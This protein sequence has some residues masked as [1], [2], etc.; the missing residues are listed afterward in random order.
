[1][2]ARCGRW[3]PPSWRWSARPSRATS[4]ACRSSGPAGAA[5]D[6]RRRAGPARGAPAA[7]RLGAAGRGRR[8]VRPR[9]SVVGTGRG[10]RPRVPPPPAPASRHR[11]TPPRWAAS[12]P[13]CTPSRSTARDRCGSCG[14][15]TGLPDGRVALYAKIHMAAIDGVT[16]AEVMTALLDPDRGRA[17]PRPT[18]AAESSDRTSS[19]GV[20]DGPVDQLRQVARFPGRLASRARH[21]IGEQ[22]AG[23]RRHA[24][25]D[26]PPHARARSDRP[27]P[28]PPGRTA[29]SSTSPIGGPGAACVVERGRSPP[30]RRVAITRLPLDRIIAD[31][32]G[33]RHDGERR[34][35]RRVRRGAARLAGRP[36]RAAVVADRGDGADARRRR[37]RTTTPTSPASS[38]PLPTNVA[39]AGRA[40]GAAP[41]TRS[42]PPRSATVPCRP[43]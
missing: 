20:F 25:R 26:R 27:V 10:L 2:S 15:S 37:R 33:G 4:A 12:S 30:H 42:P 1:M 32:A 19:G 18:A 3:T 21:G 8:P 22:L 17:A 14:S 39:D 9:P 5:A 38:S 40:P 36:R 35:R 6:V 11:A 13:A 7:H 43:R 31:Q 34:R 24:R 23:I 28:A 16:G 29:R 41:A